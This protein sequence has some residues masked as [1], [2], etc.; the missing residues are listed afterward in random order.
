MHAAV[1]Q[2]IANL[3]S[4]PLTSPRREVEEIIT[5]HCSRG[6]GC[7]T[8]VPG[9]QVGRLT[10]P[11]PP[12]MLMAEACVCLLIRGT[13][14]ITV[15]DA[16]FTQDEETYLL[17][18]V[19]VPSIVSIADAS[20]TTPYIALRIDLDFDLARQVLA[21][22]DVGALHSASPKTPLSLG[23]IDPGLF[24]TVV[25]LV[26]LIEE[27]KDVA[28]ISRLLHREILYRLLV[29]PVGGKFRQMVRLGT[30][31]NRA[32]KAVTWLQS[33]FRDALKIKQLADLALMAESTLHRHFHALTGMSPIQYQ[34]HLRLHEARRLMLRSDL[35]VGS[36]AL[37]VGYESPT[38]FIREY[39][40]LF[41]APPLRDVKAVRA[42]GL[43]QTVL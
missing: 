16:V 33:H 24:D 15:G 2:S 39:R 18:T 37:A 40:R 41:G 8:P 42:R 32:I 21:E 20:P 43:S 25:R 4:L 23:Q 7:E 28:F 12:T 13:R 26:R 36:T 11:V 35:D 22:I 30:K 6:G 29:G 27:L 9:L 34:K 10:Q 5:R 17:S 3:K 1:I 19:G 14:T 38:Q 31:G